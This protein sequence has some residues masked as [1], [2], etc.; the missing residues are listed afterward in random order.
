MP[1]PRARCP[2]AVHFD[3][4]SMCAHVR[5]G[6]HLQIIRPL[7]FRI[8][9]VPLMRRLICVVVLPLTATIV[10]SILASL[11]MSSSVPRDM[12][13]SS[14]WTDFASGVSV[15]VRATDTPTR[16]A[17]LLCMHAMHIY[18][19]L[20]MLHITKVLYGFWLGVGLGWCVC[21]AWELSLFYIYI[22][23]VR[24]EHSKF[25]LEYTTSARRDGTLFRE[26]VLFAMSSLPLQASASLVQFGDVTRSE[27]MMAN[28]I[29]T[30]V[31]S[32]K[33]VLC[34]ALLAS[35]PSAQQLVVLT[36]VLAFSTL[37]PTLSTVYVSSRSVLTALHAHGERQALLDIDD[38]EADSTEHTR[39]PDGMERD[40]EHA[41]ETAPVGARA[42]DAQYTMLVLGSTSTDLHVDILE[43]RPTALETASLSVPDAPGDGETRG[44][45]EVY[46][47]KPVGADS[48]NV[49]AT[50]ETRGDE[51]LVIAI[52]EV[53]VT[54][55][56][57]ESAVVFRIH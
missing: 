52:S 22:C 26:N 45:A 36:A 25:V 24:K 29:V 42:A 53:C 34:G 13:N 41:D 8:V 54:P 14:Q 3:T 46:E 57:D 10:L 9:H 12:G 19:C 40:P 2:R 35:S 23:V 6:V 15:R 20:P 1:R 32:M 38:C 50:S 37:L 48:R 43:P 27:F 5:G 33:N 49:G 17:L 18:M 47:H 44:D 7:L 39:E 11:T 30:A 16:V 31:M 56:C 55:A 4:L 28:G 51:T 21:C